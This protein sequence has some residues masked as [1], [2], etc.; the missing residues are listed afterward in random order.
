[1][2]LVQIDDP[3]SNYTIEIC[4]SLWVGSKSF[5]LVDNLDFVVVC[6]PT[7]WGLNVNVTTTALQLREDAPQKLL[8]MTTIQFDQFLVLIRPFE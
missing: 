8:R 4:S 6:G 1:M 5:S 3:A 7:Y 2:T